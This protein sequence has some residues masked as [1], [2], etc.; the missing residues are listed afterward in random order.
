MKRQIKE[1]AKLCWI[2]L[3]NALPAKWHVAVDYLRIHG[4]LPNFQCPQSFN[5]KI[6]YRK[7]Y[8]RDPRMPM[9]IDKIAVKEEMTKRFGADF[10]IPTLAVFND[11][12][13]IDFTALSYPCVVKTNHGSGKNLFL[14]EP[15]RDPRE[16]RREL[17][18]NLRYR[19]Y[20]QTEE[21]AYSQVHPRLLV[22]PLI[23]G[24]EHGLI[25]YKLHTF[26]ATVFAIQVDVDRFTGHRRNFYDHSW[27]RMP[28]EYLYRGADFDLEPPRSLP[29]MLR[30]ATLIGAEFRYARVDLYEVQGKVKFGEVTFYPEGGL[31][32]FR[33]R[34]FDRVLGSQ[35]NLAIS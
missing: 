14:A 19:H 13:E 29:E 30:I 31:G 11:E 5:E 6:A 18:R 21:W 24:G 26:S 35:W 4:A 16:A 10:L 23:D 25:D 27:R 17:R 28:F 7:L 33:P 2:P 22:E 9:L 12:T 8:D 1:L 3:R 20:R 32:R 15:P 34:E